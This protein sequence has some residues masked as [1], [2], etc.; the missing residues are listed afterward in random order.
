MKHYYVL[1]YFIYL[2]SF[3]DIFYLFQNLFSIQSLNILM[4]FQCYFQA[5]LHWKCF[6]FNFSKHI[7]FS[8]DMAFCKKVKNTKKIH[9]GAKHEWNWI[10]KRTSL[11]NTPAAAIIIIIIIIIIVVVVVIIIAVGIINIII[12]MKQFSVNGFQ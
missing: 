1:I 10:M 9:H 4:I 7:S 2:Y 11:Y 12:M 6:S 5:I 8:W 3:V